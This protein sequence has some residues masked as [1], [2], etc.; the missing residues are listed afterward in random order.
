MNIWI[1]RHG[2]A[3]FYASSDSERTLTSQGEAAVKNKENG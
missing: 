3:G 1:M 2:E